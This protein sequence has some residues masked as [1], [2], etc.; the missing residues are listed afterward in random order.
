MSK[1]TAKK[2][3]RAYIGNLRSRPNL[4]NNLYNDLFIPHCLSVN[5][6]TDG[7]SVIQPKIYSSSSNSSSSSVVVVDDTDREL[8][9]IAEERAARAAE[10]AAAAAEGRRREEML[11]KLERSV[12]HGA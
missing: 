2:K 7:I 6:N 3:R 11:G 9:R 10:Q 4:S 5:N 8:A 1:E 12:V